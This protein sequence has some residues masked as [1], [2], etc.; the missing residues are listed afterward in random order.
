[1]NRV[2]FV[3]MTF[4]SIK[5]NARNVFFKIVINVKI[6]EKKFFVKLV[7][8]KIGSITEFVNHVLEIVSHVLQKNVT[9]GIVKY[10]IVLIA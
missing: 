10:Q 3:K 4:L 6:I 8:N 1:M 7:K 2:N 9:L 5:I